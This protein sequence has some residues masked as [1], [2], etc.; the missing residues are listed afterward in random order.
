MT[1]KSMTPEDASIEIAELFWKHCEKF[2]IPR[3]Q[4]IYKGWPEADARKVI[5]QQRAQAVEE[6]KA[7]LYRPPTLEERYQH[8]VDANP[9]KI[10]RV[11]LDRNGRE[12]VEIIDEELNQ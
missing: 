5:E 4:I 2:G 9:G 11:G 10:I 12:T 3:D 7:S 6:Y 1:E 8:V